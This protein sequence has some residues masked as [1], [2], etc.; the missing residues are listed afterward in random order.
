MPIEKFFEEKNLNLCNIYTKNTG[1][2]FLNIEKCVNNG[3]IKYE[4]KSKY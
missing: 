2:I 4:F 1:E 3:L